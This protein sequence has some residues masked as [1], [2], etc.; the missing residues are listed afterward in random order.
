MVTSLSSRG[1]GDRCTQV[2][3]VSE[4]DLMECFFFTVRPYIVKV[5]RLCAVRHLLQMFARIQE[6][7]SD[8]V[9]R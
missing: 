2:R 6:K 3:Q 1:C 9:F 5:L 7:M 4:D 8:E